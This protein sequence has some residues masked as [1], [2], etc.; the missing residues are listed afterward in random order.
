MSGL[1]TYQGIPLPQAEGDM[2][3]ALRLLQDLWC[4]HVSFRALQ[5]APWIT[6]LAGQNYIE[7]TT[8]GSSGTPKVIRRHQDSW[9]RSFK[10]NH[11]HFSLTAQDRYA[12]FGE[13]NHSLALYAICEAIDLDIPL[14]IVS[15][16]RP[17]SQLARVID[18]GVTLLYITPTQLRLLS[19]IGEPCPH[20][21]LI[22]CGGSKLDDAL[23]QQTQ[24]QFPQAQIHEFY[25]AS[26]TSFITLST[27]TTPSGSV[28]KAY[29]GVEIIIK[30]PTQ[31]IGE[32]WLK[33]PY[34]FENYAQ[35]SS[36][37]TRYC[38]GAITVGEMGRLDNQ[39]NLWLYGRQSRMVTCADTNV[40]PERI[41]T[42]IGHLLGSRLC[43]VVA[44]PDKL[45][46]WV[47]WAFIQGALSP[48][49]E[50]ALRREIRQQ[51][52]ARMEPRKFYGLTDFPLLASGKPD[53][54][55]LKAWPNL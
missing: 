43:A 33:S 47:L 52:G 13:L 39:G 55:A 2:P 5:Q 53:L 3:H 41:E 37:E 22:L 21:R 44:H 19:A 1:I 9:R 16:L 10:V 12:V 32:V 49:Q 27:A 30:N 26:E 48:D 51:L 24:R 45:R 29:P 20:V 23:R 14:E 28:G 50:Q 25:G 15:R 35:G 7:C 42:L 31:Q 6:P 4:K 54:L 38:D 8:G 17:R 18:A 40:Y 46:G 11:Q 34:L 36:D